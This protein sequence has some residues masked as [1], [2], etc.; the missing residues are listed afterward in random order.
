MRAFKGVTVNRTFG[1][2]RAGRRFSAKSFLRVKRA[3]AVKPFAVPCPF[4]RMVL[5]GKPPK[6]SPEKGKMFQSSDC[7]WRLVSKPPLV[8][9]KWQLKSVKKRQKTKAQKQNKTFC[10][11]PDGIFFNF[12]FAENFINIQF[13]PKTCIFVPL[14]FFRPA[15][16]PKTPLFTQ[17]KQ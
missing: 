15:R 13:W 3:D 2:T 12:W 5:V 16:E 4:Q 6:I 8:W 11:T 14:Q 7:K 10:L 17:N 9:L 1:I